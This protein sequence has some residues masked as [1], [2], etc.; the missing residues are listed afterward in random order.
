MATR[1]LE[2]TLRSAM[3]I[4]GL[5]ICLGAGACYEGPSGDG[6]DTTEGATDGATD[7]A[8][9]S[10]GE[11]EPPPENVDLVLE[12]QS[13]RMTQAELDNTLA[14]LLGDLTEPARTFLS[15]D[16]FT[17]YDNDYTLQTVSRTYVESMEVLAIDVANR[18]IE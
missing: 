7:G 6:G 14:D 12:G 11:P 17:P 5:T 9:G 10:E 1:G 18:L 3:P 13:R 16:D 4:A 15:E 2:H 8:S